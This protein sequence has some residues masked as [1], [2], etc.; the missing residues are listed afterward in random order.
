[1]LNFAFM[2]NYTFLIGQANVIQN[3]GAD[4]YWEDILCPRNKVIF[5]FLYYVK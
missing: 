5:I 4:F 1:M 2:A 3:G